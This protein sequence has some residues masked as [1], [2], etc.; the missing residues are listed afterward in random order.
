[1]KTVTGLI[2]L[3]SHTTLKLY[4]LSR[5]DDQKRRSVLK[6]DEDLTV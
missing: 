1:M 6:I 4:Y 3:P 5:N 2:N